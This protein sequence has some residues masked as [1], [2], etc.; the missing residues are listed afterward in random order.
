MSVTILEDPQ[1][2]LFRAANFCRRRFEELPDSRRHRIL[3]HENLPRDRPIT[4]VVAITSAA[5]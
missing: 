2:R 4:L 5:T 3:I 1:H